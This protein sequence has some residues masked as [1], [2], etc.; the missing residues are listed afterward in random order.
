MYLKCFL[1]EFKFISKRHAT[2]SIFHKILKVKQK[3][4]KT[5]SNEV[6]NI[7]TYT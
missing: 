1:W 4:P 2:G 7:K 5:K 3:N 6:I